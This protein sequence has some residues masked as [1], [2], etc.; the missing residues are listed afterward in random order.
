MFQNSFGLYTPVYLFKAMGEKGG[1]YL[2][3]RGRNA[4]DQRHGGGKFGI[5]NQMTMWKKIK[6]QIKFL[7]TCPIIM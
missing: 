1:I 2:Q 7:S 6:K 3:M 5:T 4:H